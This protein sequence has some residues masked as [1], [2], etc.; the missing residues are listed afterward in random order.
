[1]SGAAGGVP[2]LR[3]QSARPM[4]LDPPSHGVERRR[5][6]MGE[7]PTVVFSHFFHSPQRARIRAGARHIHPARSWLLGPYPTAG[8][9]HRT[10]MPRRG[11]RVPQV[12]PRTWHHPRHADIFMCCNN[13]NT[14]T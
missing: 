8:S 12:Q 2:S 13:K 7:F 9:S 5:D 14:K 10:S 1:M 11:G 3:S 6:R 4:R